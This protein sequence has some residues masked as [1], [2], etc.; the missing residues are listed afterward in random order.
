MLTVMATV[1]T[2][3]PVL[4][5]AMLATAAKF[6]RHDLYPRLLAHAQNMVTRAMGGDIEPNIGVLQAVLL[7]VYW[8]EPL[9][10]SA[11]L[12]I[13]YAIRL[14]Y[15]LRLYRKRIEPLPADEL[16]ARILLDRERTWIVLICF[17]K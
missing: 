2:N 16:E 6:F 12:R 10:A 13:G 5:T 3:S 4:F 17:D 1:R 9:D 14:G 11:W 8:K 15:Q 7:L